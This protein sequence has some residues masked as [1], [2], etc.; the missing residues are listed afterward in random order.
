M[1]NQNA[2]GGSDPRVK[3]ISRGPYIRAERKQARAGRGTWVALFD[4]E[5]NIVE[6]SAAAVCVVRDETV[7]CPPSWKRLESVSLDT[8][9]ELAAQ[10]GFGVKEQPLT[11]YDFLNA[12]EAYVLSTGPTLLP[13]ASVD[14][15]RIKRAD[16]VGSLV[17]KAWFELVGY[18]FVA[19]AQ[20]LAGAGIAAR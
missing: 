18:D 16:V 19:Q 15:L 10:A 7:L 11:M 13:I 1:L 20:E 12:D 5:G 14:G 4:N 9:C 17:R 6:A 2:F 8:F 3:A